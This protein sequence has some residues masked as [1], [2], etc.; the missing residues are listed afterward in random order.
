M[1]ASMHGFHIIYR[2]VLTSDK[3]HACMGSCSDPTKNK[4]GYAR[5]RSDPTHY[6][7]QLPWYGGC[8]TNIYINIPYIY[9]QET[10][11]GKSPIAQ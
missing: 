11:P 5:R 2:R 3:K 9:G 8:E 10:A 7:I 1:H 6:C 4:K